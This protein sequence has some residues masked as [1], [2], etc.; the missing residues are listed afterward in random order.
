[1]RKPKSKIAIVNLFR[2]A[3]MDLALVD[4]EQKIEGPR[5]VGSLRGISLPSSAFSNVANIRTCTY[6]HFQQQR[7]PQ[8]RRR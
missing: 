7:S 3:C 1:M 8:W 2:C 4:K 6:P 5:F